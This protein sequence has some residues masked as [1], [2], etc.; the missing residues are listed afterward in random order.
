SRRAGSGR[1]KT[2]RPPSSSE[3]ILY[4]LVPFEIVRTHPVVDLLDEFVTC[5]SSSSMVTFG[6]LRA[7]HSSHQRRG[8]LIQPPPIP[9]RP[10]KIAYPSGSSGGASIGTTG[11]AKVSASASASCPTGG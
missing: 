6:H 11:C 8:H 9:L 3:A 4:I 10:A 7:L 1:R 5:C 2:N